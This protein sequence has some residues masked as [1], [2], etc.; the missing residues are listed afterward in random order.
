MGSPKWGLELADYMAGQVPSLSPLAGAITD[1][2]SYSTGHVPYDTFRMRPA[3][4]EMVGKAGGAREAKAFAK[5]MSNQMGGGIVHRFSTDNPHEIEKEIE[6]WLA[7][8]GLSNILGRW[9]RIS[10]YGVSEKIRKEVLDPLRSEDA[11]KTLK[12]RDGIKKMIQGK[13]DK[14][15]DAERDAMFEKLPDMQDL[16]VMKLINRRYGNAI[17][18][19]L[20]TAQGPEEQMRVWE[21]VDQ[22]DR[23]LKAEGND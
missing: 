3:Y 9:I 22:H 2:V 10:D 18:A 1:V 5:Y 13:S 4:P 6:K 15:T 17:L 7:I 20:L 21:W 16:T 12:A 8:P 14:V 19:A 11:E 23:K